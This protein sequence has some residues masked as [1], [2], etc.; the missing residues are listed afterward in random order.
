M[1]F[2]AKSKWCANFFRTVREAH[3]EMSRTNWFQWKAIGFMKGEQQEFQLTEAESKVFER[4]LAKLL[5]A[6]QKLFAHL[7]FPPGS[8]LEMHG[9]GCHSGVSPAG[10]GGY[11]VSAAGIL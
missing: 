10:R 8:R 3:R 6:F 5:S 1:W 9:N 7:R 2:D 4:K 11:I